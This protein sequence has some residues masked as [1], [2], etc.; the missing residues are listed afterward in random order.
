MFLEH[1]TSTT[2]F[3]FMVVFVVVVWLFFFKGL[4]RWEGGEGV[5]ELA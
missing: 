5:C 2:D 1:K 4:G 3:D